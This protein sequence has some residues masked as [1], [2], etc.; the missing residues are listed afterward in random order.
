M[1]SVAATAQAT[2]EEYDMLEAAAMEMG[3]TTSKTAAESAAALEYMAL[4]GWSVEDSVAGLPGILHLSEATGLDLATTSDL[5][6]DS[7]AALGLTVKGLGGYLDVAASANNNA[8]TS[9]E[10]LMEAYL[11]VG[12]TMNNLGVPLTESATA[13]GVLANRG[14]KG[15]EAGTA[16]N[17]IMVNLTTGTGQAGEAMQALGVSAFDSK[18]KFIG[19]EATLQAVNTAL[20]GCTDEQRNAYLAAIG[21]KHHVDALNDLMAGLNTTLENGNTEW[22]DLQQSLEGANGSLEQMR[23]TKLDNLTGDLAIFNSALQDAGIKIYKNLQ[24]PLRGAVQYATSAIYEVS[25][26][27]QEGGFTAMADAIGRV[28]AES[29]V[30]IAGYASSFLDI[31]FTISDG[32]FNGLMENAPKIASAA[33][34]LVSQFLTGFVGFY[35]K[36]WVTG[37]T[38]FGQFLIGIASKMPEILEAGREAVQYLAAGLI[39]NMPTIIEG[40]IQIISN[41]IDGL[42]QMLP[43]LIAMGSVLIFQ[44]ATGIANSAPDLIQYAITAVGYIVQGLIDALPTILSAGVVLLLGLVQGISQNIG[45]L[46]QTGADLI[47]HLIQGLVTM[48]PVIIAAAGNIITNLLTGIIQNLPA[49]LQGG[50]QIIVSLVLGI[51]QA[52]PTLFSTLLG[53]FKQLIDSLLNIDWIALGKQIVDSIKA[54]IANAWEGLKDFFSDPIGNVASL[55]SSGGQEAGKSYADGFRVSY[56]DIQNAATGAASVAVPAFEIDTSAIRQ[57]GV[58][59]SQSLANGIT[60]GSNAIDIAAMTAGGNAMSCMVTGIDASMSNMTASAEAAGV[61][62]AASMGSGVSSNTSA[63]TTALSGLASS[64]SSSIS[65]I[66]VPT[67]IQG[68]SGL[69]TSAVAIQQTS[70]QIKTAMTAIQCAVKTAMTNIGT[71]FKS[72]MTSAKSAVTTAMTNIKNATNKALTPVISIVRTAMTSVKNFFSSGLQSAYTT[73]STILGNIRSIFSS[74]M[75]SAK[76]TVSTAMTAVK[77]FFS[78]GLQ[79]AYNTVSSILN[80]IKN[81]FSSIMDSAKTTVSNAVTAIKNFFNFKWSLPALGTSI[82]ETAKNTVSKAVSYIKG[83][84]NFSWSLPKIKTPHFY[85]SGYTKVLGVSI[86]SIGVSWYKNGGI[87]DGAQIFGAAGGNLLGGGEAGKE[88]VLPLSQLWKQMRSIMGEYLA[89]NNSDAIGGV[90]RDLTDKMRLAGSSGDSALAKALNALLGEPGPAP[91]PALVGGPNPAHQIVYSPT[92]QFYGEA[93]S[94]DDLVEASRM[95]QEEFNAMM[96]EY[97][98]D[99]NRKDF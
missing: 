46:V 89:P 12:G 67:G 76:N 65:G 8:N 17:A 34:D 1:D 6:T 93:P 74:I 13:L 28:L 99:H 80:N 23:N 45:N 85:I 26:A 72:G 2:Q 61:Q 97:F 24:A 86:P 11:G 7:M 77:N 69:A 47:T 16:L 52:L 70:T 53:A 71:A 31:A 88:A 98:K 48:L 87:L 5:V 94:K 59:S 60:R 49:I 92:Y 63:L 73:V 84:F 32:L 10:Q 44:L 18:G 3:R 25:D 22:E 90:L 19:L 64:A 79:S 30:E 91:Q 27:L 54:G 81:K 95:S 38:L 58:N 51:V 66:S 37:A 43:T 36:F 96:D 55:F 62:L 29:L 39:Q 82:L 75:D 21:G 15:S 50:V 56:V 9:A 68:A 4:A 78:S 14:I 42:G 57:F 83:L 33:A 35:S 20:E 41:L 40:A